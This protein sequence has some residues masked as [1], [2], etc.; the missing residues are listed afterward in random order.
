[1]SVMAETSQLAMGPYVAIAA[2]GLVLYASTAVSREALVVKVAA[3]SDG[4]GDGGGGLGDGEISRPELPCRVKRREHAMR[5]VRGR[6]VVASGV[7][8]EG[9][10]Q[11]G[12][13][14]ARAE[15]TSN[16]RCVFVTRD[17]S[18]LSGWLNALAYCRVET[19]A[20][21]ARQGAGWEA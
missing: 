13:V 1:M 16:M 19:R 14:R 10:T 15:R 20:C 8:G 11:A 2:V 18:K 6:G 9:L 12:E 17:M 3:C 4:D 7:R 5:G 21:D